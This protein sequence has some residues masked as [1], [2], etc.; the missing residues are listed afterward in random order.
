MQISAGNTRIEIDDQG[1]AS[2]EPLLLIMGLGMQL[3]A[4]PEALVQQLVARGFRVIRMDNRDAGLSQGFDHLGMP[5]LAW[6]GL[7]YTMHLKVQAPY[8]LA[9][10]AGDALGVLDALGLQRAHVCGASL[11]GM[12]AQHLAASQA[13]RVASL[14]LMMTTSGA[15]H[16]PQPTLRV[17][18]ALL[19]R[20]ASAAPAHVVAHLLRVLAVI[21]SP[22]FE[23]SPD[24]QARRLH[25]MVARAWRP[26]GTARQLAAVLADGDRS[27]WLARITAPTAIIHGDRDPLIPVDAG[28]DL[29]A[30]IAGAT[31]DLVP[32]MGHDLP[33][34]LLSRFADVMRMNADRARLSA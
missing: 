23:A 18:A 16:L 33:T 19:S 24:E 13:Q 5:N 25:A 22:A 14:T 15:R 31:S 8:R 4:W 3:T 30:R 26:A 7:R 12:V 27:A 17:R 20:P 2:A 32:G 10:M 21:G 29:A 11:G 1:P 9:D 34:A 28:I 6:A